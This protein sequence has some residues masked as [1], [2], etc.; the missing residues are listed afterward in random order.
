[1]AA[2]RRGNLFGI[3]LVFL[4]LGLAQ[5]LGLLLRRSSVPGEGGVLDVDGKGG[6]R[7]NVLA[8][9]ESLGMEEL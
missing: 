7:V 1:M 4:L 3:L 9:F 8:R 5:F 2:A 6:G